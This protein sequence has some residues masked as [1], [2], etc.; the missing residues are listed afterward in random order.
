MVTIAVVTGSV[1]PGR[2]TLQ[3]SRWIFNIL[4]KQH[5][6]KAEFFDVA[7]LNLPFFDESGSPSMGTANSKEHTRSWAKKIDNADGFIFVTPEYNHSYSPV[8]KNAIDYLYKEWNF[9]PAT[10]VSYGALVAGSRAVEH[11]RTVLAE[12][13]MYDLRE[14]ILIPSYWEH[15][16]ANGTYQFTDR[17]NKTAE[18]MIA[19]LVFWAHSMKQARLAKQSLGKG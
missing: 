12:L 18:A 9:K 14:Q 4:S 5:D 6:V 7:D 3:P 16:D 11:L 1:R 13:K 2:F 10:F 17:Q 19:E 15:L 8:L